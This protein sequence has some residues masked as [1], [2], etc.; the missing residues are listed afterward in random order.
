MSCLT[1]DINENALRRSAIVFAPHPD[2]EVLGCGGTIIKKKRLGAEVKI[3][4]L[5]DGA[6]SH[7]GL[8]S[9]SLLK[10]IRAREALAASAT[11]GVEESDVHFLEFADG[12]LRKDLSCA[13]DRV[14]QILLRYQ[15]Q[16]VY[17]PYH[18]DKDPN[19]D[20]IATNAVVT[21]ALRACRAKTIIYEYPIWF[22][23]HWPWISVATNSTRK[24]LM[25]LKK[26]F[27]SGLGLLWDMRC[28]VYI[29]DVLDL[30]R[31]TL[32]QHE[33]Q[34]TRL[35][36]NSRWETLRDVS[37]GEFLKCFFQEYEFFHRYRHPE[38]H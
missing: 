22:W 7:P 35:V 21:S 36:P 20:H 10:S 4:I 14:G 24:I 37:N 19:L 5:T 18:K 16:E 15:P 13:I 8:I 12:K 26:S 27:I 30:K 25:V 34:M 32:D 31:K 9:E 3:V 11:M 1:S 28:S 6:R 38:K 2:D 33:S 29:A 23:N 17:I